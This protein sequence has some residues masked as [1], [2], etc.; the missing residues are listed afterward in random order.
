MRILDRLKGKGTKTPADVVDPDKIKAGSES[1]HVLT[2]IAELKDAGKDVYMKAERGGTAPVLMH[3]QEVDVLTFEEDI[4]KQGGP[5]FYRIYLVADDKLVMRPSDGKPE[6]YFLKIH[7]ETAK[8]EKKREASE[9]SSIRDALEFAKELMQITGGGNPGMN[10]VQVFELVV[11]AKEALGGGVSELDTAEKAFGFMQKVMEATQRPP[12]TTGSEGGWARALEAIGQIA[13]PFA[14]GMMEQRG[15]LAGGSPPPAL[16][17]G[18]LAGATP[19]TTPTTATGVGTRP[20]STTE[21]Q[22]AQA[23]QLEITHLQL[24]LESKATPEEIAYY[25]LGDIRHYA[26]RI[27]DQVPP[28]WINYQQDP[29]AAIDAFAGW[30]PPIKADPTLYDQIK[31]SAR[32]LMQKE[33]ELDAAMEAAEPTEVQDAQ[34]TDSQSQAEED[35][36]GQGA[37]PRE[38]QPVKDDE[39]QNP[40]GDD[41][42]SEG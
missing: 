39:G 27:P 10:P 13:A 24:L 30:Y 17:E 23:G 38:P 33:R 25:L 22:A 3:V 4:K 28:A 14:Q 32:R 11:K 9:K 35:T 41:D 2:R 20:A 36:D 1:M 18:G 21:P 6:V 19:A 26:E 16:P 31:T 37:G 7:G 5:G 15:A 8:S 42:R 29:D 12:V 40:A 34:T